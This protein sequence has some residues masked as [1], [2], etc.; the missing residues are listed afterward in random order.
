MGIS[1]RLPLTAPVGLVAGLL[2]LVGGAP[3]DAARGPEETTVERLAADSSAPVAVYR[4]PTTR[5]P[6]F[7]TGRIAVSESSRAASAA[8]RGADFWS[9]Y[10]GLFGMRNAGEELV[11]RRQETDVHG[12]THLRYAQRYR[13]LAV[14]G[15]ELLLHLRR[16]QAM[17]ANGHF[18]DG[19]SLSITPAVSR[20]GAAWTAA[21]SVRARGL[22]RPVGTP[23]LL[24][25]V[26]GLG[27]GQL[28]WLTTVASREPLG[29]WR[30]FVDAHTAEVLRLYNDLQTAQNRQTYT[31]SNDPDCNTDGA[32]ACV[33]PG[34]LVLGEASPP[35]G[36]A[37]VDDTHAHTAAVYAYYLGRHG[38]DS[39]DGAG[40]AIRSTVHFGDDYNNAFW[41]PD[42]CA[43][44]HG[45]VGDGEQVVYG[46]G[47]GV[48]FSPLGR[49]L[50]VVAHEL[51][52]A[53]TENEANLE[54]FG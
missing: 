44:F 30:V 12:V 38:R 52:H 39:Y 8:G 48:F 24:V 1:A 31:N 13:G 21:R 15:H 5:D 20:A 35:S 27:R 10:G 36:D 40:H 32:P 50:D 23:T 25:H 11:L 3:A 9:A 19:L 7:L 26:D 46:D 28:A 14:H 41:C 45:S 47:D 54:S 4:D 42:P 16:G 51:T 6:Y 2:A 37:V 43:A 34:S 49:D 22:R 29:L 53:V 33:L 18:A 17:A